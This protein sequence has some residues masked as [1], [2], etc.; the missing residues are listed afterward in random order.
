M[1]T[2]NSIQ[3]KLTRI[4]PPRVKITYD[5]ETGGA[6]ERRE[7]PF[8]VGILAD[9][10]GTTSPE[11][12]S[13]RGRKF[14]DIDRG[15]FDDVMAA[16]EPA[17]TV[18]YTRPKGAGS[19]AQPDGSAESET[20]KQKLRFLKME[21][22]QPRAIVEQVD[23]LK[24]LYTDRIALRDLQARLESDDEVQDFVRKGLAN[25]DTGVKFREE[26]KKAY[27][28]FHT[29]R[30]EA[31]KAESAA[32]DASE[33]ARDK[34]SAANKAAAEAEAEVGNAALKLSAEQ[35][36]TAA[37]AAQRDA[38]RLQETA[39]NL[40]GELNKMK[41][42]PLDAL[43]QKTGDPNFKV[44][45]QF[46]GLASVHVH[47]LIATV[48]HRIQ[49]LVEA[50]AKGPRQ[51]V[52]QYFDQVVSQ[53]DASL[54]ESLSSILRD[55]SLQALE[56]SW[57]GLHYLVSNTETGQSLKLRLLNATP[58]AIR[59]DLEH[60]VEFDQSRL[61]KL[62]YEIEFGT[63]GGNPYSCLVADMY[64]DRDAESID[65]LKRLAQVAAAAH[66][67]LVA[68]ADPKMFGLPSFDTL[69][70]P[71]DLS[72]IFEG[73]E[74]IEWRD[75]RELEESRYVTLTMPRFLLRLPH[76]SRPDPTFPFRES[77]LE[78]DEPTNGLQP[79]EA[80]VGAKPEL[81]DE[82]PRGILQAK[83]CLWGNSAYLLAQRITNAFALYGWTA[84]I[85]GA[86]GGGL[87]ES[88]PT[89]VYKTLSGD[90][91][92][93]CPTEVAITDRREKE[94]N[95]LGFVALCH[96]K[97]TN[98]AAF[99]GGQSVNRPKKYISDAANSNAR[100][101]ALL[102]HM[103]AASRFAHY[104]K[105]IMRDKVGAFTTR[106][107][108][109]DYLTNWLSQYILL[110]DAAPQDVKASYPLRA[111][112]IAVVSVPG[113]PGVYKAI[114]FLKPHFQLEEL[115]TSIRLV[116]ELPA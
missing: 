65:L 67:P 39:K 74:L 110:D 40:A 61:F 97:G 105:V 104:V 50:A 108:V 20:S 36:R 22:F 89:Y 51:P 115:T 68:A 32:R 103:L 111:A 85:R 21:D 5:V 23:E 64:F 98:R 29:K 33:V 80:P 109:Q 90:T 72:Q 30:D 87:V 112:Q 48:E 14:V 57:R 116:A 13:L 86:E 56:A 84:A 70:K 24:E 46:M 63:Y 78:E 42:S 54:F 107:A 27:A 102:P 47:G 10:S 43:A 19:H 95:D 25:D 73:A 66:A 38:N 94:L 34:R 37:N 17:V 35:A 41:L 28:T 53:I 7:L 9:L 49:D 11:D 18:R 92:Q 59:E 16:I 26:L 91:T 71:R 114:L 93:V 83:R 8:I 52:T 12:D 82:P 45:A 1:E 79:G 76:G 2:K 88:L 75:F 60:A 44:P 69:G 106:A 62:I 6:L 113:Q 77:V 3:H 4:R 31:Q 55:P 100:L 99:F 81:V 96:C 101:S 58:K 15:N